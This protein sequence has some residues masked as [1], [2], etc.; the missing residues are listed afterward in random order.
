[1][2][3]EAL[4]KRY[5]QAVFDL[6]GESHKTVD[7]GRDL[8][9]VWSAMKDDDGVVRFFFAPVIERSEKQRVLLEAFKGKIE[10]IALHTLLLLV[11]KRRERLL[12]E[13]LQQYAALEMAARGAE[14]LIVSSAHKL[15]P[16]ELASLVERLSKI[17]NKRF[18][19]EERVDPNLLG[20]VSIRM[21]DLAIDGT[22]AGRLDDLSRTLLTH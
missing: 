16:E 4:A 10:P 5:A 8:R 6:A 17:Y 20:G 1:M 9:T 14:P 2:P 19:V 11:R 18:E 3:N 12:P 21:G 22:V 15:P 7:V 13:I